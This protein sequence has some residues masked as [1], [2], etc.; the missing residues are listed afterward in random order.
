MYYNANSLNTFTKG[1]ADFR[2]LFYFL[3]FKKIF[4]CIYIEGNERML[5]ITFLCEVIKDELEYFYFFVLFLDGFLL[6]LVT[7]RWLYG[8]P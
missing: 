2:C 3:I 6:L 1:I 5:P 7:S 8:F 4:S